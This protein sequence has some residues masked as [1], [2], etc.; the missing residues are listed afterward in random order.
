MVKC[1]VAVKLNWI[2]QGLS[3]YVIRKIQM[4]NEVK[5]KQVTVAKQFSNLY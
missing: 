2:Q 4:P 3:H 5:G 1:R